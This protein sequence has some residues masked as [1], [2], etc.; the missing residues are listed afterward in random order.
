MSEYWIDKEGEITFCDGDSGAEVPNHDMVVVVQ[1]AAMIEEQI[2]DS[3][4]VLAS[5]VMQIIDCSI[6]DGIFDGPM[7]REN[8][9]N[10]VDSWFD[11]G[12]I[13]QDEERDIDEAILSRLG[14]DKDL[15]NIINDNLGNQ[16]P[17]EY[18]VEKWG[19]IRV[20]EDNFD[21]WEL[22]DSACRRMS[23]FAEDHGVH[24]NWN[25]EVWNGE[26]RMIWG[27]PNWDLGSLK[28]IRKFARTA[29]INAGG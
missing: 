9:N 21:V 14:I 22:S 17:R 3:D 29:A 1:A 2:E 25:I 28:S 18:A 24:K 4:D 13:N 10:C 12:L 19:W 6:C 20:I 26:E 5:R 8:L 27:V 15:W 11:E 23:D 16:R 7:F